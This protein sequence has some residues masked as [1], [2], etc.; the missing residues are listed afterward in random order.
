MVVCD[1]V[2]FRKIG[3]P[4]YLATCESRRWTYG[5]GS[6]DVITGIL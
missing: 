2:G 5:Y 1:R 3:F 6:L 4:V